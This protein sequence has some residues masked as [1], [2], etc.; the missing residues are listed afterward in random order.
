MAK[1]EVTLKVS[2]TELQIF[3]QALFT[4][5]LVLRVDSDSIRKLVSRTEEQYGLDLECRLPIPMRQAVLKTL[6]GLS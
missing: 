3:K 4:Y 5:E 1:A 2:P 6:N